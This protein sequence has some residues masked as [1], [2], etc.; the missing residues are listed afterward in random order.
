VE[1]LGVSAGFW[2]DRRVLVTGAPGFLGGWLVPALLAGGADVVTIIRDWVPESQLTASGRVAEVTVVRGDVCDQALL[3]RVL[4]E[5]E[6]ATVLHLAA[7][8]IVPIANRN[9][10][11]TFETN[12]AGTWR[13][14]EACRRS[15]TVRQIVLASSDKAYGDS[16]ELPYVETMPLEAEH[17]YDVSKACADLIARAYARTWALPVVTTRCGN[18]FGGGDL[19]WSRVVPGT[20]RSVLR[21][22]RPVIRS[23][24]SPVRDYI[25]VEDA[26]SAYLLLAEQLAAE[27][28]LAG[29]AFNFSTETPLAV[30]ALVDRILELMGSKLVPVV[31]NEARNEIASQYL[32]ASKARKLLG[33]RPLY[34]LDEGLRRTSSWYREHLK[35]SP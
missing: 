35:P 6:I 7:Q 3:E 16:D 29:E 26:V 24:G 19:N 10:V 2:R 12:I 15:P 11:S 33:W 13:L 30:R 8:A 31:L 28:T 34:G 18:F 22:E 25:Y 4:G 32:D 1:A 20:I 14:L 23:D 5:Y 9:P 17:P 21:G 27:P